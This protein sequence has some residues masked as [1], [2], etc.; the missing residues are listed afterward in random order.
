MK[1]VKK[2]FKKTKTNKLKQNFYNKNFLKTQNNSMI[3]NTPPSDTTKNLNPCNVVVMPPPI[4]DS[5][6]T[7]LF[8]GLINV[9][10]KKFELDNKATILNSNLTLEKTLKELKAKQAECNRLKNEIIYL[11]SQLRKQNQQTPHVNI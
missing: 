1:Q 5:D 4:T 11:K 9:V 10:K 2:T 8:N 3:K 6:I 7:A